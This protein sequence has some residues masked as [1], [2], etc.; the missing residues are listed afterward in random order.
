MWAVK[1]SE[2]EICMEQLVGW[3]TLKDDFVTWINRLADGPIVI[4]RQNKPVGVMVSYEDWQ[5]MKT[6]AS[7][8]IAASPVEVEGKS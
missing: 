6:K 1:Q 5:A 8:I 2:R 7:V 3:S 4:L